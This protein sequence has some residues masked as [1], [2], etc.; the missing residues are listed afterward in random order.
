MKHLF[1]FIALLLASPLAPARAQGSAPRVPAATTPAQ[2]LTN[3]HVIDLTT[4]GLPADSII[5]RIGAAPSAFDLSSNGVQVLRQSGV[6]E[7]VLRAMASRGN[8]AIHN[9]LGTLTLAELA[10]LTIPNCP[11][12]RD[13][14]TGK[15]LPLEKVTYTLS[16][17]SI[18]VKGMPNLFIALPNLKSLTRQFAADSVILLVNTAG[19]PEPAFAFFHAGPGKNARIGNCY[20]FGPSGKG[21]FLESDMPYFKASYLPKGIIR[22]AYHK[23]LPP[24]EYFFMAQPLHM[25]PGQKLNTYTDNAYGLGVD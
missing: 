9:G 16:S 11:Y 14:K 22:L 19:Q 13:S 4:K 10:T 12:V 20:H 15:W 2:G 23:K 24:G 8:R 25:Q 3:R 7:A 18:P 5:A 21:F 6:S 1:A 17:L